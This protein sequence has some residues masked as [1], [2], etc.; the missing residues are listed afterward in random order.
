MNTTK[1]ILEFSIKKSNEISHLFHGAKRDNVMFFSLSMLDRLNFS[2]HS[3][4]MLINDIE[5]N[6][7][8][9]YSCGI[10]LRSVLL[11]YMI[12]LN[13]V[14][15]LLTENKNVSKS[16]Y[17]YC[18]TWLADSIRHTI[19]NIAILYA[20][21]SKETRNK[22][23]INLI[24]RNPDFFEK[25]SEDGNKPKLKIAKPSNVEKLFNI[26][27]S[28][29]L[30]TEAKIYEAY[31]YYSKY[32]HF[33]QMFYEL[34]R[35]NFQGRLDRMKQ[36][37]AIFPIF[38]HYSLFILNNSYSSGDFLSPHIKETTNFIE[39]LYKAKMSSKAK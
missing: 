2:S 35:E 39:N 7:K 26:L 32:D 14:N 11:D 8:I 12:L 15:I 20:Q 18:S 33:G 37:I 3:L 13:G 10:I 17:D 4:K 30:K 25:Y 19:E 23:Y 29:E 24:N 27:Q 36:A 34:S 22:M 16:L 31:L 5:R 6:T 21:H 9:E 1:K 28:S 38:L